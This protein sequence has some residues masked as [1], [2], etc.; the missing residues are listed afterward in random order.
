MMFTYDFLCMISKI[1]RAKSPRPMCSSASCNRQSMHFLP[2]R[3]DCSTSV[4]MNASAVTG[5][6][7]NWDAMWAKI[8]G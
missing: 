6:A 5:D 2:L 3:C 7:K 4:V 8:K 1:L